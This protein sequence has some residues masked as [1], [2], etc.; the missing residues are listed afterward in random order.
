ME[1]AKYTTDKV[2]M[3][4]GEKP[5]QVTVTLQTDTPLQTPKNL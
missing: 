1:S 4:P 2:E 3:I 5:E